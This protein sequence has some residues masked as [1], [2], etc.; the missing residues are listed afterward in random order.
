LR[1]RITGVEV[2]R[3]K[4][5]SQVQNAIGGLKKPGLTSMLMLMGVWLIGS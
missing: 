3:S 2:V 4:E 1:W 5:E